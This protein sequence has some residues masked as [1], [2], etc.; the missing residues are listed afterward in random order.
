LSYIKKTKNKKTAAF[1]AW[2][3][4]IVLLV[5][6]GTIY[7]IS[8]SNLKIIGERK[9][10]LD[11]PLSALPLQIRNWTGEDVPIPENIRRV[12]GTDDYLNRLYTDK[13]SK[14]WANVYI[15]YTA[16]PRTMIGHKPQVCYK[17]GGWIHDG[18]EN[19]EFTSSLGRHVLCLIHHFHMPG[20]RTDEIVVLN[21][22]I[23]N[24]QITSDESVFSGIS[25]RT[26]N[27]AGDPAHYVAQVQIS[28]VAKSMVLQAA[29]L[30]TDAI[31]SHLPD[32]SGNISAAKQFQQS[33]TSSQL[34]TNHI[35]R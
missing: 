34:E 9:I 24:G 10:S 22:Y 19:S 18:T 30:L 31:M 3:I 27:I 11:V 2:V 4:A 20:P 33:G 17:A 16:R 23:V 28:S 5:V 21:F 32:S 35:N 15:A 13:I 6:S 26:P 1:I 25:W 14:S 12:A 7:R 8:A 29:E